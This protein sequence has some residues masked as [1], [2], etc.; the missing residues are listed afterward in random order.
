MPRKLKTIRLYVLLFSVLLT[1]S[2]PRLTPAA[3]INEFIDFSFKAGSSTLLPGRL[4]VPPEAA[5]GPRPLILYLHGSGQIGLDNIR[6]V[7]AFSIDN[8]LAQAKQRGAFVYAPQTNSSWLS[9]TTTDRLMTMIDRAIIDLNADTDS[10]YVTGF[11]LGGAGTWNMLSR[12]STRFSAG[13]PVM[14]DNPAG[15]FVPADLIN[16]SIMAFHARDDQSVSVSITRNVISNILAAAHKDL[17]VFPSLNSTA[18]F[19]FA[20][21]GLD[22]YYV[23]PATGGHAIWRDVSNIPKL[24]DWMFAHTIK[25]PEP[26]AGILAMA[27]CCIIV[28]RRSNKL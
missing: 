22:L 10:L 17:P 2:P 11:S 23:E 21:N 26:T 6:Q 5:S 25:V 8:L 20:A 4:Y 28:V 14:A 12:Y 27:A 13:V 7:S 19:G 16:Q 9:K 1:L 3:D 24:Y 18:D 15:D